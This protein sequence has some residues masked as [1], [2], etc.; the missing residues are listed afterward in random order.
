VT[1]REQSEISENTILRP[2][3]ELRLADS[4]AVRRSRLAVSRPVS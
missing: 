3:V 2:V 1:M 4:S